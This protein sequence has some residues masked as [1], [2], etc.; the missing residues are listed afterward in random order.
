M[1]QNGE[2][3]IF[4]SLGIV[5]NNI[6]IYKSFRT[7]KGSL[8]SRQKYVRYPQYPQLVESCNIQKYKQFTVIR[9][10]NSKVLESSLAAPLL[11]IPYLYHYLAICCV[12]LS[13]L[14][15]LLLLL[16]LREMLA[17]TDNG[18]QSM[19]N[20]TIHIQWIFN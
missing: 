14:I 18:N 9:H 6:K 3:S 16:L 20:P 13:L 7:R 8:Y 17:P 12:S 15:L 19:S 11:K 5:K 10:P 4:C 1:S 2:Y